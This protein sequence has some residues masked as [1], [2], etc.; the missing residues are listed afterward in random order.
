[1]SQQKHQFLFPEETHIEISEAVLFLLEGVLRLVLFHLDVAR[2]IQR[3]LMFVLVV[4]FL[5]L[6]FVDVSALETLLSHA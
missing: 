4:V 5:D 6:N 1:M 2:V 3:I